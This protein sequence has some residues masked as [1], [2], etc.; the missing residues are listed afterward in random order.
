M[1][2]GPR[3][4]IA[5][6][7]IAAAIAVAVLIGHPAS[8]SAHHSKVA[9]DL[10]KVRLAT[11]KYHDID[12]AIA[13]GYHAPHPYV[14]VDSAEGTMGY[15]YLKWDRLDDK[16]DMRKPELL[17]YVPDSRRGL[18]LVAVEYMK[19]D[20]DQDLSTDGDRPTLFNQPFQGPM[21]EHEAGMGIHYDLHAW[22]WSDNPNGTFAQWNPAISC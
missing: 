5:A 15:H 9:L 4:R 22:V 10:M 14:C 18:R 13:D 11:A 19:P 6:A 20:A 8:A 3:S 12:K 7:T 17:V 16:L 21:E 2:Q 1:S